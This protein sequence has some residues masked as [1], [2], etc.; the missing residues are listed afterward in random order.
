MS[1]FRNLP[2]F[3]AVTLMPASARTELALWKSHTSGGH[4]GPVHICIVLLMGA[5]YEDESIDDL[6]QNH[7]RLSSIIDAVRMMSV[8][9]G[10]F[11]R[12]RF[13]HVHTLW[14]SGLI[15]Q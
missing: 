6:V 8:N 10:F 13:K 12:Y 4:V 14:V 7:I 1:S 9:F 5:P 3:V 11:G 15:D 2:E